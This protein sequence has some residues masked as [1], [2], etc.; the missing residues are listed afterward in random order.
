[1]LIPSISFK[2]RTSTCEARTRNISS[3]MKQGAPKEICTRAHACVCVTMIW[4]AIFMKRGQ[5]EQLYAP[6]ALHP[7]RMDRSCW[8]Q[9]QQQ[10]L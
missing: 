9:Q 4:A 10:Q 3:G 7:A 1:M 2:A 8:Q 6:V 5:A